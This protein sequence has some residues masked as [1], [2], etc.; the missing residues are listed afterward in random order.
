M[1]AIGWPAAPAP[2]LGEHNTAVY[3]EEMGLSREDLVRLRAAGVV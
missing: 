2:L 1:S 3:C